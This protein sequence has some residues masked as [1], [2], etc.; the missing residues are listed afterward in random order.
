MRINGVELS[1]E[2]IGRGRAILT[3]HGGL[4][5]DHTYFRPWLDPLAER[6]RLIF[7]DHRGNGRSQRVTSGIDHA[8]LVADAEALRAALGLERMVL[9]GHSYGSFLALQYALRY[10]ERLAGLILANAAPAFDYPDVV[11]ANAAA[12]ATAEMAPGLNKLFG[13]RSPDDATFDEGLRAILP[14]YFHRFDPAIGERVAGAMS[15]SAE[16]YNAGSLALAS[17]DVRAR[18]GEVRMPTLI[19]AGDDHCITPVEQGAERLAAG[20]PQA[21]VVRFAQSGHFPFIEERARFNTIVN[22]WLKELP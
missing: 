11:R 9:L 3:L 12:R 4:G 10:P 21:R 19:H 2:E 14:L 20:I 15:Y 5:F 22:D 13:E 16:A 7:Y 8:T 17:Y 18:L 6:A 1:V